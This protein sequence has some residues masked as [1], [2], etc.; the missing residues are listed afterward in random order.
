MKF[1]SL[2]LVV[3]QRRC[4][5]GEVEINI[6]GRSDGRP[7]TA[8]VHCNLFM[9]LCLNFML[10]LDVH[11]RVWCARVRFCTV[12]CKLNKILRFYAIIP[13]ITYLGQFLV[14]CSAAPVGHEEVN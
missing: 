5:K 1:G 8:M 3:N 9:V 10:F 6:R 13:K 7:A 14:V 11:A 12:Q 2:I 4:S